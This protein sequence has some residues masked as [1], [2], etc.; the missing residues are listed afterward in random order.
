MLTLT[1]SSNSV[2]KFFLTILNECVRTYWCRSPEVMWTNA[3]I[4]KRT[5]L[6]FNDTELW[7]SWAIWALLK[8]SYRVTS[9]NALIRSIMWRVMLSIVIEVLMHQ[10][11]KR[12][13][14]F[15]V[16]H[17]LFATFLRFDWFKIQ[18]N[19]VHVYRLFH[20]IIHV[21]RAADFH[22]CHH[23]EKVCKVEIV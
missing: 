5:L 10:M 14:S 2:L 7:G 11:W 1:F 13:H 8:R 4:V 18:G 16:L 19:A 22:C 17:F 9:S 20:C 6:D 15:Y 21:T 12:F 23:M 3:L